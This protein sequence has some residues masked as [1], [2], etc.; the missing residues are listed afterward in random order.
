M[1]KSI[2]ALMIFV[3]IAGCSARYSRAPSQMDNACAILK[4]RP[5][6]IRAFRASQRKWGVPVNVLMATIHQESKFI[7]NA[8]TP[9]RYFLGIIPRGRVSSAYGYAQALDGTWDEYRKSTGRRWAQRSDIGDAADFIGWYMTTTKKRNGVALSDVRN[10][11]LA[12]HEGHSGYARGT[13][14]RKSWLIAV[15]NK[16]SR[17]SNKYSGQ[18]Q[19]CPV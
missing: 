5:Q 13:H 4:Q 10:Q 18:L 2:Y 3:M 16:V 14:L 8:K 15:A 6:F 12:Y 1:K 9:R 11:Y 19:S 17:R 7:Q